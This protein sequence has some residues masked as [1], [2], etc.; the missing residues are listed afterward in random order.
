[1]YDRRAERNPT[2]GSEW[3]VGGL[4]IVVV[5]GLFVAEIAT[6]YSPAKLSALLIVLFWIP[7]LAIHECGHAVAA[8]CLDW[9]VRQI[10]IGSGKTLGRF[11]FG[12]AEVEAKLLPIEGFVRSRPIRKKH[13]RI[14]S[15]LIYFSGPGVE[16][17]I[18]VSVLILLDPDVLLSPSTEYPIIAWQS[19]ALAAM[20]HVVLNLIPIVVQA[21]G[22]N[23][24]SDGL[25]ILVS[26][27]R[28]KEEFERMI[29]SECDVGQEVGDDPVK[30]WKR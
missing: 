25:G 12:T 28:P 21:P 13:P 23:L 27:F 26:L 2:S 6:N 18:A 1:M 20:A 11:R 24:Y 3:L 17:M 8:Y 16:L 10:V 9:E 5:V 15:A 19:L 29:G 7:L 30:W 4:L 22:G 14:E